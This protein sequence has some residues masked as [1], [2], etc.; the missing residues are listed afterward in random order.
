MFTALY[1]LVA[2]PVVAALLY[3][4]ALV[5]VWRTEQMLA[6]LMLLFWPV[7]L[8]ALVKYWGEKEAGVRT[9]LL[10][11]FILVAVWAGALAW[12][13]GYQPP[14]EPMV[15]D[16]DTEAP[17]DDGIGA[18]VRRSVALANLPLRGGLVDIPVAKASIDVPKHFRFIDRDALQAAFAGTD[19]EPEAQTVGW[20]VHERVDLAGK[21]A[22]HVDVDYLADGF[23][24]DETF[25]AQSRETLL[26]AG[27]RATKAVSDQQDAGEP[28]FSLV[29][30]AEMP[31]LDPASHTAT[32]VEEIA[33][34]GEHARHA[35]DCYS[36]RLGRSG[37]LV[38]TIA[39]ALPS[40]RE[41][42]LRSVR[43]LAGRSSFERGQAYADRSR[44]L[45]RKAKY[46]LVALVTGTFASALVR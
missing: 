33:Y 25:A 28:E 1:L 2:L 45:D 23:V 31:R 3:L 44:L 41:L 32:W 43:L 6:V 38:F 46:D 10:A 24:S 13:A 19:D 34:A 18:Q 39:D 4:L 16:D 15:A 27:Q 20:I 14:D 29:D 26:A 40:Q 22:W 42:C 35:L 30:Y 11:S 21:N 5:R 17:A 12:G 37:A 7:G 36:V 8:Y 9:P